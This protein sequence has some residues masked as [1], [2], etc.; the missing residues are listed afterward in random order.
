MFI[1][2]F[3]ALH[4]K[5]QLRPTLLESMPKVRVAYRTTQVRRV[6]GI[7][8][9]R[10]M[11]RGPT[12]GGKLTK[13]AILIHLNS[14]LFQRQSSLLG[15]SHRQTCHC[16]AALCCVSVQYAK[17][18]QRHQTAQLS[19]INSL[20]NNRDTRSMTGPQ[21][22][23]GDR[24]YYI[25]PLVQP[26][27]LSSQPSPLDPTESHSDCQ[28]NSASCMC[29]PTHPASWSRPELVP[30]P[31]SASGPIQARHIPQLKAASITH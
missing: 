2:M 3:I 4:C 11:N 9:R 28:V 16:W 14:H 25:Q 23:L 31:K 21:D 29:S 5:R 10:L 13:V 18:R 8:G 7:V 19:S 30:S 6:N 1:P 22:C 24:T 26:Q 17:W 12:I 15:G 20:P 27:L